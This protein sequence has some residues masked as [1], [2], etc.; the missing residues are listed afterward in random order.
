VINLGIM[1]TK[2]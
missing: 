2:N 1:A